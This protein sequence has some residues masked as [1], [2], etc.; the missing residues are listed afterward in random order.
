MGV[1]DNLSAG[2]LDNLTEVLSRVEFQKVDIARTEDLRAIMENVDTV[3]HLAANASVPKSVEHPRY[4]FSC[5]ALSTLNVLTALTQSTVQNCVL[6]SSGAVYGQP[7]LF[8]ITEEHPLI[9][10]SPYGAS[11]V[12]CEALGQA[13]HASYGVPVTVARIFNTYGPRQPRVRHV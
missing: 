9:P 1:L 12:S 6:A 4:D 8:P 5:N 2:F 10:I 7:T 13:F 3:F 11:K